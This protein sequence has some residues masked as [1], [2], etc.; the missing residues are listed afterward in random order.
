V[1]AAPFAA[2]AFVLVSVVL[3]AVWVHRFRSGYVPEWDE[4]GYLAIAIAD[5]QA[6]RSGGVGALWD[7]YVQEPSQAPLVPLLTAPALLLFGDGLV[8]GLFV[9]LA[10]YVALVAATYLL[11]STLLERSWAVLAALV[12]ASIPAVLD[13]SRLYHFSIAAAAAYTAALWAL[14]RS[15]GLSRLKWSVLAGLFLGLGLLSRTMM[16]AYIPAVLAA[17]VVLI[18]AAPADR[19]IRV[20]N[21]A[22]GAAVTAAVAVT[23]YG[24]NLRTIGGYLVGFGYGGESSAYGQRPSPVTPQFWLTELV[25]L[26]RSFY[27]PLAFVLAFGVVSAVIAARAR[28][29]RPSLADVIAFARSGYLPL[30]VVVVA[31]YLALTSSPNQGTAFEFP[32][33]PSLVV[34]CVAAI[35]GQPVRWLR[36]AAAV[37]VVAASVLGLAMKSGLVPVIG[38]ARAFSIGSS[39]PLPVTD[40]RGLIQLEILGAGMSAGSAT[41]PPPAIQKEWLP[42]ADRVVELITSRS[43]ERGL[44]PYVLVASDHVL[45]H[46]TRLQ[47]AAALTLHRRVQVGRL[48][49]FAAAERREYRAVLDRAR[50]NA[51]VTTTT[52]GSGR[53]SR[54]V[55]EEEARAIGFSFLGAVPLPDGGVARVFWADREPRR[56][57]YFEDGG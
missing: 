48:G 34:L 15:S 31:G 38:E 28:F 25:T 13:Y 53:R 14:I 4:S 16:V 54:L 51:L 36:R 41:S 27:V 12:T 35:A 39:R 22:A 29:R 42:A 17:A 55:V 23:W 6:L 20:R 30:V 46:N 3:S 33:L 5:A 37:G 19:R 43:A 52:P 18:A 9:Q 56:D 47:L 49:P 2:V 57:D 44:R 10:L 21:L 50:N 26:V 40:G 32:W 11:A 24:P 45:F 1:D 8:Q 7:A